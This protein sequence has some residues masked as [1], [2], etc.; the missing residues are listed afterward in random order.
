[1]AVEIIPAD[2]SARIRAA[3]VVGISVVILVSVFLFI[4]PWLLPVD[5]N[6]SEHPF[7]AFS[8]VK[9]RALLLLAVTLPVFVALGVWHLRYALRIWRERAYP[10]RETKV[11]FATR[12]RRGTS[13]RVWSI[14][15]FFFSVLSFLV[16]VAAFIVVLWA[17][18]YVTRMQPNPPVNADARDVPAHAGDRAA[19][20]GYRAR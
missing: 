16:P 18:A 13:A 6:W 4:R 17:S 8:I 1:M 20:A 11:P 3:V 9:D 10:P 5:L 14:A 12:V 19:R 15:Y 7:A 2:R